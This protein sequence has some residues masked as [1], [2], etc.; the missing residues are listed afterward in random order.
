MTIFLCPDGRAFDCVARP[1]GWGLDKFVRENSNVKDVS[2][3]GW[4]VD[5]LGIDSY[6]GVVLLWAALLFRKR[7]NMHFFFILIDLIVFYRSPACKN[8]F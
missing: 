4:G 6:M 1:H 8:I 3:G 5:A 2:L 7:K